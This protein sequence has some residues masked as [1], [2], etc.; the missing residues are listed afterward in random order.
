MINIDKKSTINIR[1]KRIT[2]I[3]LGISGKAASI[4]ANHLGAIVFASDIS[5][6]EDVISNAME[7]MHDHHIATETG[8]HTQKIYN[9]DLWILSPG[10]PANSKI[11]ITALNHGIPIVSEIEF[12]SWYTKSQI[13]AITGSN[14]KTT[15][16]HILNQMF[17]SKGIKCVMAGNIGLSFSKCVF[18]EILKPNENLI[19]LIEISSFQLEFISIFCPSIA[20]YTNISEDH[21][22]RHNSMKEYIRMKMR[23]VKNFKDNN[24]IIFNE[25]D[26]ILKAAFKNTTLKNI[27]F[28]IKSF[29]GTF[30][31]NDHALCKT[32]T[33]EPL[34]TVKD[35]KLPG[36]HNLLNFLAAA[37]CADLYGINKKNIIKVLNIFDGVPHRIENVKTIKNVDYINDSKATNINSV[38]VAIKTYTKPVILILGGYNKGAD[39]RLLIPH[40][41]SNSV[42]TIITYG[43]AGEQ[44]KTAIG[45]AVRSFFLFDLNSAVNQ[46]HILA[47][48]G[49]IVLLSPGCASFDQFS[50]F[51]DR[52]LF[53]KS[54]VNKL[55]RI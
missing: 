10:I 36:E 23:L 20:V 34:I 25:D 53:F 29:N 16:T 15:T 3:G 45:D 40:I 18:Q 11:V 48:P 21:L 19:Y 6:T 17:Q 47:Q 24:T 38:I 1:D 22:D 52:G 31:I 2:V 44:I 5:S 46:A 32:S 12:A 37:T 14:G 9:S 50:N 51:E 8:I 41:K 42:K 7:L 30:C 49:D 55:S 27:P 54:I 43:E 13:I 33:K 39:F 35:L 4:L 28:S 26:K